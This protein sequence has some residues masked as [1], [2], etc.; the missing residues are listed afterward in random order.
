MGLERCVT[1]DPLCIANSNLCV[2][3]CMCDAC[4]DNNLTSTAAHNYICEMEVSSKCSLGWV[5]Y[6]DVTG[7]EGGDSCLQISTYTVTS[8]ALASTSCPS[9]SHLLTIAATVNTSALLA[10][11]TSLYK[12]G[13][14]YIGCSQ[15]STA[16][17][18]GSGWSWVD[19]TSSNNL[20][21][22]SNG[23]VGCDLWGSLQPE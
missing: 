9:G 12:Y 23:G 11:S 21:C 14:F 1:R 8:W 5:Y 19:S 6:Q 18:R 22:N 15:S 17:T 13:I 10:F 2:V 16:T 20:N 3:V 7:Q 4:A